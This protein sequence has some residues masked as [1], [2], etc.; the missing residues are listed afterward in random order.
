MISIICGHCK[1]KH[2]S[3]AAAKTCYTIA[4]TQVQQLEAPGL[5][6]AAMVELAHGDLEM[7]R[8]AI[9]VSK[10]VES[11]RADANPVYLGAYDAQ[12]AA[13]DALTPAPVQEEAKMVTEPGMYIK[14]NG[15]IFRVKWNKA[16]T[17]LY[18]EKVTMT[19][20][21]AKVIYT[22]MAG[23]IKELT[24]AMRMTLEQAEAFGV[25]TFHC[26]LC[27]RKLSAKSSQEAG[28][29]PICASKF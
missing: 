7:V 6:V 2:D 15:N 14:P 26:C 8:R 20:R 28:I 1:N 3:V 23:A 27:G 19:P 4:T 11:E 13:L 25:K 16:K 29:D 10:Q 21:N 5:T 12:L 9:V 22:Y 24:P 18:A 17:Y